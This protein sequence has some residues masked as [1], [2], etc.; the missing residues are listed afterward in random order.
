[1]AKVAYCISLIGD[2]EIVEYSHNSKMT[3]QWNLG[4]CHGGGIEVGRASVL[5]EM[6]FSE[7]NC[8]SALQPFRHKL[9]SLLL[10]LLKQYALERRKI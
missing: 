1:M 3:N 5:R 6:C 7:V 8:P 10:S 2:E 9:V 4:V